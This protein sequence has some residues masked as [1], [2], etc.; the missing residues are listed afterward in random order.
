MSNIGENLFL[1]AED[2][3]QKNKILT[4]FRGLNYVTNWWKWTL[5]NPKLDI[6]SINALEKFGENPFL[7]TQD[8]E[9]KL[10]SDVIQ[11]P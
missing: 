5:N 2:I 1:H 11:G 4:S 9:C 8:I 10:I 6:V 3:E 7:R